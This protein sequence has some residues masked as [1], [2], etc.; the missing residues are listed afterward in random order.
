ML[1]SES[2]AVSYEAAWTLISLS[3]AP[4]AVRYDNLY[5]ITY[6]LHTHL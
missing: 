2:A 6:I 5:M 1:Q 3:A 4:T